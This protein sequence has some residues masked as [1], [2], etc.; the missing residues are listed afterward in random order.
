MKWSR[1]FALL[2]G[3][4]LLG[5]LW[6]SWYERFERSDAAFIVTRGA[7]DTESVSLLG[8]R[9]LDGVAAWSAF[10]AT[11]VVLATLAL[12]TPVIAWRRPSA[13]PLFGALALALVVFRLIEPP[14]PPVEHTLAIGAG[15]A[16]AGAVALCGPYARYAGAPLLIAALWMPWYAADVEP[17]PDVGNLAAPELAAVLGSGEGVELALSTPWT[18]FTLTA[19]GLAILA[20]AALT[21]IRRVAPT[22]G[23]LA[24]LLVAARLAFPPEAL[25]PRAGAFI[26]LGAALLAWTGAW[27]SVRDESTPGAAGPDVPRRAA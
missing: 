19:V 5:S 13:A 6:L 15:V 16:L 11:D 24:T 2:G 14:G 21:R 22:A 20:L 3:A 9:E 8:M 10:T 12:A 23:A 18:L 4:A 7:N 1:A 27:L 25:E 17:P 26:A